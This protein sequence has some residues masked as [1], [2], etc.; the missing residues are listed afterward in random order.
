VRLGDLTKARPHPKALRASTFQARENLREKIYK[1]PARRKPTELLMLNGAFEKNPKRKRSIGPKSTA[2]IGDP[3]ATLN[4]TE[5]DIWREIVSHAPA[6]V[7]TLPDAIMLETLCQLVGAMRARDITDAQR[8][9]M[10][11]MLSL[12]GFTPSDRS[13][14]STGGAPDDTDPFARFVN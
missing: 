1:M 4:E 10:I 6:G 14:I 13:R 8:G 7:L 5:R 11:K 3:P 2:A 9:Q 12:I